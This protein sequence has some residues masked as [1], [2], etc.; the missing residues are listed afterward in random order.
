MTVDEFLLWAE[1]QPK[2]YELVDGEVFVMA[3]ERARHARVKFAVQSAL[4][5]AIRHAKVPCEVLPDGMTVRIEAR[6][7]FE[8]DALVYCGE[9]L[10]GDA[11][12]V[13]HPLIVVEVLSPSTGSQDTGTKLAGYFRVPSVEHYLIVDPV[14]R[15]LIHHRRAGEVIE[16]RIA[17]EGSLRLDPPGLDLSVADLFAE[18]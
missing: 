8:P 9:R 1:R 12:E 17:S 15:V 7:A 5:G 18:P 2:R 4:A 6:T 3:P 10:S 16:T 13:P 11:I 14:R